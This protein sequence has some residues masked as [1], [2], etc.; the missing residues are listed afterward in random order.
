MITREQVENLKVGDVVPNMF[1]SPQKVTKI[2]HKGL[3]VNNKMFA[4]YYQEFGEVGE[5]SAVMKEGEETPR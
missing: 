2:T 1:G 4:C 3:D 5:M